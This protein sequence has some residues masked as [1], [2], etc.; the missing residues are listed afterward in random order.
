MGKGR[1]GFLGKL[2]IAPL[3]P[4]VATPDLHPL[5]QAAVVAWG[6]YG[7]EMQWLDELINLDE[8]YDPTW[9]NESNR[10]LAAFA[11]A[12]GRTV[13]EAQAEIRD[14]TADWEL[15]HQIAIFDELDLRSK[16][17]NNG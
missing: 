6:R 1:R 5:R 12:T 3:V 16:K 11:G 13:A 14:E 2:A 10:A 4:L 7:I 15:K 8:D 9:F 17:G